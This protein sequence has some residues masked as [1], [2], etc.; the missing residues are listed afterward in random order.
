MNCSCPLF[1]KPPVLPRTS[2]YL[3]LHR[4]ANY[5]SPRLHFS[6]RTWSVPRSK[7]GSAYL[8][9]TIITVSAQCPPSRGRGR[10][11]HYLHPSRTDHGA[12]PCY[13]A[14]S[15][16]WVS[17]CRSPHPPHTQRSVSGSDRPI[18]QEV[19]VKV[20]PQDE[21]EDARPPNLPPAEVCQTNIRA[22]VRVRVALDN[23]QSL[24]LS[25][26]PT[27]TTHA[28]LGECKE[29]CLRQCF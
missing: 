17:H 1:T 2:P 23:T 7:H 12:M 21:I 24:I 18:V 19:P 25:A 27:V 22:R 10:L 16:R 28:C 6:S 5:S 3:T 11:K 4:Y 29:D 26:Y 13:P 15:F 14:A 20:L 8:S 9:I